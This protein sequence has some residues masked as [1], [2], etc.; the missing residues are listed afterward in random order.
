MAE[1]VTPPQPTRTP[2]EIIQWRLCLGS[3]VCALYAVPADIRQAV[4][5]ELMVKTAIKEPMSAAE[6]RVFFAI[7]SMRPAELITVGGSGQ[8]LAADAPP[9]A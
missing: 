7:G 6:L 5:D 3:L 2:G 8:P 1:P 4:L 9:L